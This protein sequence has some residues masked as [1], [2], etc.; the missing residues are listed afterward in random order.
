MKQKKHSRLTALS[1]AIFFVLASAP[2]ASYGAELNE[3]YIGL[4]FMKSYDSFYMV[5]VDDQERPYLTPQQISG[6]IDTD[7]SCD[8]SCSLVLADTETEYLF[9][10]DRQVIV[11]GGKEI[12][13]SEASE[14][15]DGKFWIR[16]DIWQSSFP[17][18]MAWSLETYELSFHPGFKLPSQII[19]Q[20]ESDRKGSIKA[21]KEKAKDDQLAVIGPMPSHNTQVKVDWITS[22]SNRGT[23]KNN[24]LFDGVSDLYGGTL[25][26]NAEYDIDESRG[27]AS[28]QYEHY[29]TP[30]VEYF[31]LGDTYSS[32]SLLYA[33]IIQKNG[34]KIERVYDRIGTGEFSI[35]EHTSPNATVDVYLNGFFIETITAD[36]LGQYV[37]DGIDAKSGDVI[38]LKEL[39]TKGEFGEKSIQVTGDSSAF[40]TY[41]DWDIKAQASPE[42]TDS[43]VDLRYGLLNNVTIG[44]SSLKS[45]EQSYDAYMLAVRPMPQLSALVQGTSEIQ[46]FKSTL[47]LGDHHLEGTY[48]HASQY[49]SDN[50]YKSLNIE[51]QKDFKLHHRWS[52]TNSQVNTQYRT[53]DSLTSLDTELMYRHKRRYMFK[54][55]VEHTWED[56][57]QNTNYGIS[58]SYHFSSRGYTEAVYENIND[59]PY[60]RLNLKY[61]GDSSAPWSGTLIDSPY[62]FTAQLSLADNELSWQASLD[63]YHN[64]H[65][66]GNIGVNS[67]GYMA[68][69]K[70]SFGASFNSN[71]A[72]ITPLTPHEYANG[73]IQ[74]H[75]YAEV[76]GGELIPIE[77][78]KIIASNKFT[79]TDSDGNFSVSDLPTNSDIYALV[80]PNSVDVTMDASRAKHRI[81]LRPATEAKVD[82]VLPMLVGVD[83][84]ANPNYKAMILSSN[85]SDEIIVPIESDGFFVIESIKPDSYSIRFMS[86]GGEI[87][88]SDKVLSV[89]KD[90][91]WLSGVEI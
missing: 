79:H 89:N 45:G 26:A 36:S 49:S 55:N 30:Y 31:G 84:Y 23:I 37:V 7:L 51:G 66:S 50:Q 11:A 65:L 28:W 87:I 40:L 71:Q 80:T 41:G 73:S 18:Y 8:S 24:T 29:D 72:S 20:Y 25:R 75:V 47:S 88:E 38:T 78:A 68:Q 5:M 53:L 81:R 85:D 61:T 39:S 69:F 77:S 48:K 32:G 62:I 54:G 83:G 22:I 74:G 10:K 43:F 82:F 14:V 90:T 21:A 76:A 17:V 34:I 15:I 9:D 67:D 6:W 35:Q 59:I 13:V 42:S 70:Y 60:Y 52:F 46:A 3:S 12:D 64:E 16:Y 2:A 44:G 1:K 33:P 56:D 58:G 86:H 19:Q 4:K 27:T 57:V 63:W 91:D